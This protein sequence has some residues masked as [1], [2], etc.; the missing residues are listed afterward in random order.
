MPRI[1]DPKKE[2]LKVT[3][4]M[5]EKQSYHSISYGDISKDLGIAKSSLA[6]HFPSKEL[7]VQS[8]FQLLVKNVETLM[9]NVENNYN[10]CWDRIKTFFLYFMNS[11]TTRKFICA[12]GV[13]GT[14][15]NTLPEIIQSDLKAFYKMSVEWFVKII[16]EGLEKG[17]IKYKGDIENLAWFLESFLQG[18]LIIIRTWDNL[19]RAPLLLDELK[20]V[21]KVI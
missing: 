3:L 15:F 2:I 13:L 18:W 11:L 4:G 19:E 17:E 5:L 9:E 1:T 7:L 14:E 10:F 6:H 8:S 20:N 12:G 16:R 21:L